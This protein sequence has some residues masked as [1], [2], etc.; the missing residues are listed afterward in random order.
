MKRSPRPHRDDRGVVALEFVLALP[1]LLMLI[2]SVVVLGNFLS[3]KTQTI[4]EARDGARA[5]ALRQEL[6]GGS[7]IVGTPCTTPTDTTKF[8][9]VAATKPVA[10]RSIPFTPI[11]L[12]EK[13]TE[14]VT[15][16]CG[17]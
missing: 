7:S 11:F 1:F 15:M 14:T 10:L 13:I 8:V 3:I 9:T 17:G 5:A 2:M 4:G 6:P 16:R 12:P